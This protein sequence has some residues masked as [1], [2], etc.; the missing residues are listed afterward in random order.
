[1]CL[2]ENQTG[3]PYK[4]NRQNDL[5]RFWIVLLSAL[6]LT[7]PSLAVNPDEVLPDAAL[8][9]RAREISTVL[10]CLVCQNQS[11]D[12]S[13]A[14]LAKDLRVLVR[15]RLTAGDS[16]DETIDYIVARYGEYVL[17][18][19]RLGFHTLILWFS[20][21]LVLL[22]GVSVLWFRRRPQTAK[23]GSAL[24]DDEEKALN[25]LLDRNG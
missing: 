2:T 8:E 9:S 24:S 6:L 15:E 10:R 22:I 7:G 20:P 18:K 19:P 3:P 25:D 4:P 1:M 13:D 5:M 17:L 21:V 14:E 11:I 23:L 16:D 12:D